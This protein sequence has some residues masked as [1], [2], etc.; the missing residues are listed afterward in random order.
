MRLM[1]SRNKL[2]LAIFY[3]HTAGETTELNSEFNSIARH[4]VI[5]IIVF[6]EARQ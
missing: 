5:G 6:W 2:S 3:T 1:L 4:W